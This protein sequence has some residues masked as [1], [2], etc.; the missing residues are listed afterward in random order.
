VCEDHS[1]ADSCLCFFQCGGESGFREGFAKH[2]D[3]VNGTGK[4]HGDAG[5][6]GGADIDWAIGKILGTREMSPILRLRKATAVQ[7]MVPSEAQRKLRN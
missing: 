2:G 7:S 6:H 5:D 1:L 4:A 3:V